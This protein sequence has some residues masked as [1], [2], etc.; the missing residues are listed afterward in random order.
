MVIIDQ[1]VSWSLIGNGLGF[2]GGG[3]KV[4]DRP[5]PGATKGGH[6]SMLARSILGVAPGATIFDLPVIPADITNVPVFLSDAHA[7]FSEMLASIEGLRAKGDPRWRRPWVL[8]NAWAAFNLGDEYPRGKPDGPKHPLN[9]SDN[10]E[11]P[12]NIILGRPPANTMS[13]LLRGIAASSVRWLGAAFTMSARGTAFWVPI[14]TRM[15]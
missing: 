13:C 10:P 9:Y 1:G 7:A 6:G 3:W 5:I 14:R 8:V 12:L 4:P 11:H 2:F 15:C